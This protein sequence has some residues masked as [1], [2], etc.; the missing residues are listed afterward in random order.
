MTRD[1]LLAAYATG[2]RNFKGAYLVG[3]DLEG[4]DLRGAN[5]KGAYLVGAY[6]DGA[7]LKGA[8][9]GDQ[10]VIQGPT[11]S[12]GCFFLYVK[13]T[14]NPEPRVI[15]G[16]RNFTMP[17]ARAHWQAT[18]AGTPLGYETF[19]ILDCLEALAKAQGRNSD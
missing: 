8:N 19:I 13:L 2:N 12:D 10:W 15:A 1:E 18:R 17:E 4:A 6:L 7:N 3:A 16:C 14:Q 9:L 11:R 5:L